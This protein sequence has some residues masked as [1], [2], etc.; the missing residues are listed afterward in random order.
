MRLKN[1]L[2]GAVAL[3]LATSPAVAEKK[4]APGITDTEILIGQTEPYSGPLSGF[5]T[6][7]VADAAFFKMINDHGGINGRKLRIISLDDG[8]NPAKT[9]EQI[10]KMVEQDHVAFIYR[11]LGTAGEIALQSYV[12]KNHIPQLMVGG[13]I[14]RLVN[15]E[16]YPYTLPGTPIFKVE[17]HRYA[18]YILKHMPNA[19]VAVLAS[20]DDLGH[21]MLQGLKEIFGDKNSKMVVATATYEFS[22][23][24][25]DSQILQL[26]ASGADTFI[27]LALGKFASQAI[28][29]AYDSGWRP[30]Q[31][32]IAVSSLVGTTL[33]PAGFDKSKGIISSVF[34]KDPLDPEWKNDADV[35][36][37][38]AWMNKYLPNANKSDFTYVG[39]YLF[40]TI[41]V[42][43][44]K[45]CGDDLTRENI[46]HQAANM[47]DVRVP[48]LLPGV[49]VNTT[50]TDYR[51][52]REGR[53]EQF[54]GTRWVMFGPLMTD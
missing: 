20:D 52:F 29:K 54:D 34:W 28:S 27:N 12:T 43:I 40:G 5:S 23:P 48:L 13:G 53:M 11:S 49:T 9:V 24:T 25:V 18:R 21:D 1:A 16:K 38:H 35:K 50:P 44:L 26:Q 22:D 15:P 2:V 4:S 6:N 33:K 36:A 31:F 30:H 51:L 42:H 45:S 37:W 46:M 32:L 19:K 3:A 14:S 7:G 39:G 17:A 8:F 10:R 41:L 47:H